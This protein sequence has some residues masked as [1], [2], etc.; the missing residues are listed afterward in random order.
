MFRFRSRFTVLFCMAQTATLH[1]TNTIIA[2]A[3]AVSDGFR[4]AIYAPRGPRVYLGPRVLLFS[5]AVEWTCEPSPLL[6]EEFASKTEAL[7]AAREV[8]ETFEWGTP[9]ARDRI[10]E[11]FEAGGAR[12]MKVLFRAD[13]IHAL[14]LVVAD[15]G[16]TVH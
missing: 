4:V 3:L 1:P 10:V 16:G 2:T 9:A 6:A 12:V 14:R 15:E 8:L 5:G 7:E 11:V 13:G